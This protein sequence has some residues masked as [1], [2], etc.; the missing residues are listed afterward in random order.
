MMDGYLHKY[1][2]NYIY[3]EQ[4]TEIY[5]T[6]LSITTVTMNGNQCDST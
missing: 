2:L 5:F 4:V 6:G 3:V 1:K